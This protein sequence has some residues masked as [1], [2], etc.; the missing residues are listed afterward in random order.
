MPVYTFKCPCGKGFDKRLT[1]AGYDR[2]KEGTESVPCPDCGKLTILTFAPGEFTTI[3]KDGESGGWASKA[4]KENKYRSQRYVD[5]GKRT[6]ENVAPTP[7]V[8]NYK[9]EETG[10]WKEAQE[11]ARKEKG[12]DAAS[13]YEPRVSGET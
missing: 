4:T 6:K 10:T 7:L 12:D 9:G 2:V 11:K 1:F 13:T 3:L 5:M 8:P